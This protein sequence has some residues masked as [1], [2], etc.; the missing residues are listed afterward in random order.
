MQRMLV[1]TKMNKKLCLSKTHTKSK[2]V[3][4]K[5]S[6]ALSTCSGAIVRLSSL[7]QTSLDSDDTRFINSAKKQVPQRF[8]KTQITK[9]YEK[10][11]TVW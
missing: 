3:R 7:L 2:L 8:V 5:T 4:S 6:K 10:V 1:P 11:L 9:P